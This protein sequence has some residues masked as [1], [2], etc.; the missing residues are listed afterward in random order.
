M[1]TRATVAILACLLAAGCDPMTSTGPAAKPDQTLVAKTCPDSSCTV[2]SPRVQPARPRFVAQTAHGRLEMIGHGDEQIRLVTVWGTPYQR[3]RAQGELLRDEV[4]SHTG[5]LI[6]LMTKDMKQPVEILDQIGAATRPH[7]PKR[8]LDEL[9]G[10]ADGSGTPLQQ[11]ARANLIGEASE[12]HCSLYGAWGQATRANGHVY[13]LRAL[14]YAVRAEIQRYPAII[15]HVPDE[16]HP[17]AN[18]GW[19]GVV[20]AVSGISS[21]RIALSEIG[22][23]YDR[24]NDTFDGMPFM[25]MLRDI[26]QFDAGLQAAIDRVRNTPRTSSLMYA[27]GDGE[28]GQVR[29]LQTSHTLCN[30]F[31]DD[32]LQPLTRTHPRIPDVVYHGM[33]WDV[34]KYDKALHDKLV[35]HYG[36]IDAK[37][38]IEDILPSVGT[39]N[40]QAVVYDLTAMR[41]WVA[42]ARA[43]GEQGPLEAYHRPFV[44]IDMKQVF[45]RAIWLSLDEAL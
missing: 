40:L 33:S 34:P 27:I 25:Y 29:S 6:E 43:S 16:G 15:V 2:R 38:T 1:K 17:F 41:I 14:D 7:T 22:D 8:F 12:W 4:A 30:V 45:R 9:K 42:N 35:E 10:I 5:R 11:V 24:D 32:T 3:G 28:F 19:A 23:D 20:G 13:Q 31:D 36:H 21:A 26:L 18:I 39:G 44:E 37:V